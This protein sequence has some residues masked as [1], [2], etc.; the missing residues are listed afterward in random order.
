MI[1]C[2][3]TKTTHE[4][5]NLHFIIWN[6]SISSFS[7]NDFCRSCEILVWRNLCNLRIF[8][9][10]KSR[11]TQRKNA[12][13]SND[14]PITRIYYSKYRLMKYNDCKQQNKRQK[15]RSQPTLFASL[16]RANLKAESDFSKI[17]LNFQKKFRFR[18]IRHKDFQ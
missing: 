13:L 12:V 1:N 17:L 2:N 15:S 16:N 6:F 14:S 18:T 4:K 10:E 11:L 7:R 5:K 8:S 3:K 9:S